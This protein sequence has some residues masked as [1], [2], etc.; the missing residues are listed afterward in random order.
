MDSFL[1]LLHS[2]NPHSGA[3]D[4][5]VWT[6]S[7]RH[8]FA[9]K[10]YCTMLTSPR[11]EEPGSFPWKR[12]WKVKAPLRIAFFL[13]ATAL[14][15]ILTVDNLRRREFQLINRCCLC[16]KDE[17]TINHLFHHC[18]FSVDIWHLVPISFGVSWI[19]PG[20]VPQLLHCWKFI[21]HGHHREAFWKVIPALLMWSIWRERNRWI[22]E[23]SESNVL[24]LK[25]SFLRS[26]LDWALAHVPT[27]S[28]GNLVDLICFLDCNNS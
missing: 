8:G 10:S 23:N 13:W 9:V 18:E 19:T 15:R 11:S 21:G 14:G 16:K 2:M 25:S 22:F 26:L 7:S 17:E 20:N 28:S 5:M 6:S 3:M 24:L 1:T 4:S 12:I 27:F